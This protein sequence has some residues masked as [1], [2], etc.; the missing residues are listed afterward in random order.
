MSTKTKKRKPLPSDYPNTDGMTRPERQIA[1]VLA[2]QHGN[3]RAEADAVK[4][5]DGIIWSF[6]NRAAH[7]FSKGYLDHSLCEDLHA[8][9]VCV[10]LKSAI[11]Q[12]QQGHGAGWITYASWWIRQACARYLQDHFRTVRVPVHM[13][14]IQ[15]KVISTAK[16]LREKLGRKPTDEEVSAVSGLTVFRIQRARE[17]FSTRAV[18]FDEPVSGHSEMTLV[19]TVP[20]EGPLADDLLEDEVAV[21]RMKQA[22]SKLRGR[23]AVIVK[24]RMAG[25]TLDAIGKEIGLTRERVR[26]LEDKA[27]NKLRFYYLH[28]NQKPRV[29]EDEMEELRKDVYVATRLAVRTLNRSELMRRLPEGLDGEVAWK[30]YLELL[31]SGKISA[32]KMSACQ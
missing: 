19:E 13:H 26:Q 24:G 22:V 20:H 28:P 14:D 4:E 10:L 32:S 8:E 25:R 29:G 23:H 7:T 6:A 30:V 9:S 2:A 17:A 12:Y 11:P 18:S 15:R 21:Q 27:M 3:K 1:L 5:I 16:I 31:E